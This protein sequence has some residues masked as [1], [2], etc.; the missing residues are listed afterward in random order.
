MKFNFT[1]LSIT[2]ILVLSCSQLPRRY[3]RPLTHEETVEQTRKLYIKVAAKIQ[4]G[5]IRF[6]GGNGLT[7]EEAIKI[8]GARNTDEGIAAENI[9]IM[10]KHGNRGTEWNKLAQSLDMSDDERYQFDIIEIEL[11]STGEK[12]SYYFDITSFFGKW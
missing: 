1:V 5:K 11:I 8:K 6:E 12:I 7:I 3:G 10:E 4:E 2:I 9:W